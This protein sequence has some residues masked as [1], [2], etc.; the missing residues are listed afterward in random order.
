MTTIIERLQNLNIDDDTLVTLEYSDG[1][2]VFVHNETAVETAVAETDVVQQFCE[3]ISTPGLQAEDGWGNNILSELRDS[4]WLD[5]YERDYT[6]TEYL[7]DTIR[8]NFYDLEFIEKSV[9]SY[10]YKRGF[11]TLSTTVRVPVANFI[12]TS[13]FVSGWN[14][15]VTTE[16]GTLTFDS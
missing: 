5:N 16:N 15:S 1:V 13:P 2:D 7:T 3:L 6:F 9:E 8:E 12:E 11:C 10:D 14:V 4:G